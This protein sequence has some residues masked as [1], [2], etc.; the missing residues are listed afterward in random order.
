MTCL[1]YGIV[2]SPSEGHLPLELPQGVG[3]APVKLIEEDGLGAAV[4]LIEPP[5]LT[6]NVERVLSYAR[7][8]EALHADRT[9]LPMR[10]GCLF[11][12][13]PRVVE[14][15]RLHREEYAAILREL[16]GCVEIGVRVLMENGNS[17]NADCGVLVAESLSQAPGTAYLAGRRAVYAEREWRDREEGKVVAALTGLFVRWKAESLQSNSPHV[18]LSF[19]VKREAVEPFRV[20]FRRFSRTERARLLLSGPWPP[21]NFAAPERF[22]CRDRL[23]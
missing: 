14:L 17:S 5:D 16:D 19:L 12:E 1:L 9:V 20:A 23:P 6:P 11:R 13:E 7:V 4:S 22:S 3:G 2:F 21:Y 10:Y 18:A 15:L 8:V